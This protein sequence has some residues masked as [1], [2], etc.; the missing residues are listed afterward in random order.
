MITMKTIDSITYYG[1]TAALAAVLGVTSGAIS[2]WGEFVPEWVAA[3]LEKETKGKL[4]YDHVF[5][6]DMA[7]VAKKQKQAA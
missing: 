1:T 2:Q 5:Y 7:R 4:K 3:R 6:K